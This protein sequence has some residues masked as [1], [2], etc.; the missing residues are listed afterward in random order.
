MI[1]NGVDTKY[2]VHKNIRSNIVNILGVGRLMPRKGYQ[3]VI[4]A[5]KNVKAKTKNKFIFTIVGGGDYLTELKELARRNNVN[6]LVK[7]TGQIDYSEIKKLLS[8][9]D[10]FVHPS[11][12]EGMPLSL[13]EAISSGLPSI[14]T[15][16]A[17]NE[18]LVKNNKN[19]FLLEVGDV[20]GITDSLIKL[21]DDKKLRQKMGIESVK[22]SKNYDWEKISNAYNKIYTKIYNLK[23]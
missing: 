1:P 16:I 5:L 18:D 12:A 15:K 2:F 14:S 6:K 3:F 20:N 7:F 13:L 19:G 23:Q 22:I 9:S 11:M 21:I 10:I 8:T 4:Q 17:G